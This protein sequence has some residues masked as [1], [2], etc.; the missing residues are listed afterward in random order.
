M[1]SKKDGFMDFVGKAK[2]LFIDSKDEILK[3]SRI[4]K[5]ML[6][7]SSLNREK[8]HLYKDIGQKLYEELR[9]N[10][11]L[12]EEVTMLFEKLDEIHVKVKNEESRIEEIK[13]STKHKPESS[14][15]K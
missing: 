13:H 14:E 4:G 3:S 5:I 12:P 6:D 2:T 10:V 1:R 8:N 15:N 7:I 11:S 9:E